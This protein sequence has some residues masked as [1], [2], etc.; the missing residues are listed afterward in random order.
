ME[1]KKI[2]IP[3]KPHL[4]PIAAIYLLSEYGQEK[5]SGIDQAEIG[6]WDKSEDPTTSEVKELEAQGALLIDIGNGHFDHHS[7][8]ED[9]QETSTS[10]VAKYLGIENNPELSSL[11]GYI[12]E[13][14][15][16]G[17]HNRYGDIAYLLKCM[18]KQELPVAQVLGKAMELLGYFQASQMDWHYAVK[19]E[20]EKTCE[21][22]RV[23]RG[24]NK[25]KVGI[26]KS[27]NRQVGNYGL[28]VANLGVV[29]QQRSSGHVFI[30]TNK[31][32]RIDL[33]E[34]VGAIRKRELELAG[35]EGSIDPRKL[36]FEGKSAQ[37]PM[38]FYHKTLNSFLNGSDA[39]N[40][41]EP[42]KVDFAQIVRFALYGISSDPSE[43][44][45]CATGGHNC[46]YADYGFSK[47][48]NP[49]RIS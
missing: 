16:E 15:L 47:C 41:A 8:A 18:Y 24:K 25:V 28:T 13:D 33:R 46:P 30:L 14:D 1:V 7:T 21:I 23:K 10:L 32:Q 35:V 43:L 2:L 49:V 11:L 34:I 27:D 3:N 36:Q 38:W 20:F 9:V 29:I 26:I 37:L 39:L 19:E 48:K 40:K 17:L 12:R 5:F 42:T 45:D 44:C 22:I 4:D 6:F 31:Y